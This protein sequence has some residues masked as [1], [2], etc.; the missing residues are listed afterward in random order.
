MLNSGSSS[1]T[2]TNC[3]LWDSSNQ[4]ANVGGAT[5]TITYCDVQG[6][7]SGAGNINQAPLLKDPANGDAHL[8][9]GSPCIDAGNN[10]AL[11]IPFHDCQ[12]DLR[13][14][15]D[16]FTPDTG[17]G[18]API[19]D[20]GADEYT[21]TAPVAVDDGYSVDEDQTLD[22]SA[23]GVL[24]ND[25][26][27]QDTP[28][29]AIKDTDPANGTLTLNADGS[30]TYKPSANFY[31][32]DSFNYHATDGHASSNIATVTIDVMP[33]QD[34][35]EAI[36]DVYDMDEDQTL[37]IPA[38]GVLDNDSDPDGD[39][40]MA[41]KDT[42]SSD[43]TLTFNADGSFEYTPNPDFSGISSFTYHASDGQSNSGIATVTI[44][45]NPVNDAPVA[46]A[47][48]PYTG[49][50][51]S[52]VEFTGSGAD[53][54]GDALKYRWDF[55][56]DGTWDT[57]WSDSGTASQTWG[58]DYSGVV[59]LEVTDGE[60]A[61]TATGNVTIINVAPIVEAGPDSSA[62]EGDVVSFSGSFT[63]PG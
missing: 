62:N 9:P 51:G 7:Y 24:D 40:L 23:Q 31:G 22:V 39:P 15:D 43:G 25:S 21:P 34:P 12:S 4:I 55:E 19:V 1:P 33:V 59:A 17:S 11:S 26:D 2:V 56:D 13:R 37:D 58:D 20:M 8:K 54:D 53:I 48:D 3:I 41:V 47:G 57:D 16:S 5:P 14:I 18:T 10:S 49:T 42:D 44:T 61:D 30:F 50:E 32:T 63:D 38:L 35:P 46:E 27:P 28:L 36:E 60:F 29:T 52:P 45:I 6:G